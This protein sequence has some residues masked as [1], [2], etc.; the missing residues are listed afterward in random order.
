MLPRDNGMPNGTAAKIGFVVPRY[1]LEVLG[2]A[3]RLVRGMAEELC[4]RGHAVEVLT[5]CTDSMAEWNN[6]YAPGETIINSVLV[7]RF[8]IDQLDEGQVYRT[9]KKALDGERVS[10]GEQLEFVRQYINSQALYQYLRDHE[11]AF[12]CFMFAPYLFGTTYLGTQAVPDKAVLLP[13]LHD[14]PYARFAIFRELLEQVRGVIFNTEAER[15]FAVEQLGMLNPATAVVG[16][17]FDLAMLPGA[18]AAFRQRHNLPPELLVYSGRLDAGKNVPLLLDYFTH[19]KTERPGKLTLAISGTGDVVLPSRPDIVELG[20]LSEEELRDAYAA[21]TLFCQPSINE[22]FS[23]VIMEA[24]LQNTP[25]LV[26]GDC[27]VTSE[28]VAKSGG[29]WTFRDY[30]EFRAALDQAIGDRS[31]RDERGRTGRAY[32]E[33]EYNWDAVIARLLEALPSFTRPLSLYE[34]LSR[35]GI[36]R[37][38][39]FSRERFEDLAQGLTYAQIDKLRTAAQVAMPEYQ[40]RSSTPV[41]GKLIAWLRRNL[42]S[43]LREP[44]LDPII[45]KQESYNTLLLDT[46]LPALERS[47]HTQQRLERQIRLLER[48]IEEMRTDE[49]R[50]TKDDRPFAAAAPEPVEAQDKR[51][52]TDDKVTR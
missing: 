16:Y 31:E 25:V 23:I 50:R 52:T 29:G 36:R 39:E 12:V 20:Y 19:Y 9:A 44:Y 5:T 35:R 17:G 45:A 47:L 43:H 7:R 27:A 18:G 46:L 38:L 33:R 26:H 13:C 3:E 6:N 10:Y 8:L 2:G 1:G 51:P 32:V 30:E 21:A 22:S 40:V 11:A 28:H 15:R 49:G 48:Q 4:S 14:E 24:W 41:V 34:Q 37:S 42:T